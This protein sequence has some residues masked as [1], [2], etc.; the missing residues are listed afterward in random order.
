[1]RRRDANGCSRSPLEQRA[2]PIVID[3]RRSISYFTSLNTIR[4]QSINQ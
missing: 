3:L 2:G 1:M 4:N